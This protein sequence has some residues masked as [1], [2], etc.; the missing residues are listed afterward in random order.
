[1]IN[2]RTA[3]DLK[4]Q[5][6]NFLGDKKAVIGLSGGIDS[7]VVAYLCVGAVGKENVIGL[8]LPYKSQGT[9]DSV[10]IE[11]NLGIKSDLVNIGPIVDSFPVIVSDNDKLVKGNI[12]AR[13]RMVLLYQYANAYNGM[14]VGT[15]NKTEAE[16]GYYTKYGDGAVDFE[17]IV[18]LYKGEV[19]ELAALIGVPERIITKAPSAGLWEDQTDE[20]ELGITYDELDDIIKVQNRNMTHLHVYGEI[21]P[22]GK[23]LLKKYG[24]DKVRR[25]ERLIVASNHKRSMPPCFKS[26]K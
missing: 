14:V 9:E 3:N 11:K 6:K 10:L 21:F 16:I 26:K 5:I 17:P 24:E 25:V 19:R 8:H 18:D 13:I 1:M 22:D 4:D 20:N 7:S 23:D 12:M 15:T 2:I